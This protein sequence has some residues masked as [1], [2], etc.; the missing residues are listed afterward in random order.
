MVNLVPYYLQQSM[1]VK[2]IIGPS[3]IIYHSQ[4]AI[5]CPAVSTSQKLSDFECTYVIYRIKNLLW[6]NEISALNNLKI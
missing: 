6:L 3:T 1:T 5:Y 2:A 4:V